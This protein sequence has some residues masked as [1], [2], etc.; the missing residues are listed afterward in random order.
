MGEKEHGVSQRDPAVA[1]SKSVNPADLEWHGYKFHSEANGSLTSSEE[2][3][4]MNISL[5]VFV[6]DSL[7]FQKSWSDTVKRELM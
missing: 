1:W 6:N 7:Y 3:F 2:T 4:T 5:N